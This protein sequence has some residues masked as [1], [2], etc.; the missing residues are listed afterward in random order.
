MPDNRRARVPIAVP[1]ADPRLTVLELDRQ[2]TAS[3]RTRLS[4]LERR[5]TGGP[6]EADTVRGP[7][8]HG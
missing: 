1:S 8:E 3:E 6:A 2:L 4:N 7:R 5:L